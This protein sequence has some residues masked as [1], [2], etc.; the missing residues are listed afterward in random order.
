[1]FIKE[2]QPVSCHSIF[3]AEVPEIF[4]QQFWHT[5]KKVKGTNSYEFD[6]ANKK[7]VVDA[8]V[9][10][11]ILNICPRVQGED[12]TEVLDDESTLTFLINLVIKC[13]SGKT[14]S[15][16]R[17]R[18][19]RIDILWGM[20]YRENVDYPRL[21]WDDFAFQIDHRMEKQRRRENMS[22]LYKVED[23]ATCLVK[24]VK[25]GMIGKLTVTGTP[26]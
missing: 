22:V 14:T 24:Y 2:P 3:S 16:D 25:Y 7:C 9:F 4:M 5:I 18:K 21:I 23:I 13:L 17:L 10:Q 1:M 19:S 8:E 20:F 12:F 15:N 26:T 11:M 6:L